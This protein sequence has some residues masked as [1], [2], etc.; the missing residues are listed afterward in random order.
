[1]P[2]ITIGS[3]ELK[4]PTGGIGDTLSSSIREIVSKLERNV[5][6]TRATRKSLGYLWQRSQ[7]NEFSKV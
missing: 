2:R 5:N 3:T 4:N 6:Y 1:M 7:R